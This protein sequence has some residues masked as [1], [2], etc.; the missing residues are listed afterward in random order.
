MASRI[1]AGLLLEPDLDAN[2]R[3]IKKS[4]FPW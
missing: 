1:V 2:Y 3:T 4:A